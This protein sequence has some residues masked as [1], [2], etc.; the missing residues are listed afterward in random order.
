MQDV[1]KNDDALKNF[2]INYYDGISEVSLK[3]P[4][5]DFYLLQRFPDL[6]ITTDPKKQERFKKL[7]QE[8]AKYMEPWYDPIRILHIMELMEQV[9]SLDDGDILELGTNNGLS[10]K[11]IYSLM[12]DKDNLYCLDTYKG[13]DLDDVNIE[14]K[15]FKRNLDV[16]FIQQPLKPDEVKDFILDGKKADNVEMIIGKYPDVYTD[17][18]SSLKFRLVNF[19]FDLYEPT[20]IGLEK[21]WDR[22]V[23][24]G[25]YLI[26]DYKCSLFP[27]VYKATNE[28]CKEKGLTPFVCADSQSSAIIY[29][30]LKE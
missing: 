25:A 23:P 18:Y 24:G 22:L 28:F 20:A 26:H 16:D 8:N 7:F 27:G 30:N 14:N 4:L 13:F 10:A 15:I 6:M 29:K 12:N 21:M 9:N 5:H 11:I 2:G 3:S 17:K 19:D 1:F